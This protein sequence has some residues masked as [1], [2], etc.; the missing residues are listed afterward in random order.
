MKTMIVFSIKAKDVTDLKIQ[1][2][3]ALGAM[4]VGGSVYCEK[5]EEE[6]TK[7]TPEKDP[8]Q[9]ELP[10]ATK[11]NKPA[12]KDKTKQLKQ[13]AKKTEDLKPAPVSEA[14]EKA[15]VTALESLNETEAKADGSQPT[16][17]EAVAALTHLN[18]E[19]G[20]PAA[21]QAL[22]DLGYQRMGEVKEEDYQKLIDLCNLRV[23][24][25]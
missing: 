19:K 12:A 8:N 24:E 10:L 11:Q 1:M 14:E 9:M 4:S 6:K 13:T 3:E 23:T 15:P 20:L 17:E 2:T 7:D 18:S 25:I 5:K 22:L 21:R 16:K